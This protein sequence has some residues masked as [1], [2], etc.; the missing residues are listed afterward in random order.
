LAKLKTLYRGEFAKNSCQK[1]LLAFRMPPA[2]AG[3][4]GRPHH[5]D[6]SSR[7]ATHQPR[8]ATGGG[9]A[10]IIRKLQGGVELQMLILP[11]FLL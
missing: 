8:Q 5:G 2:Y 10:R 11:T 1:P 7:C 6:R 4:H 9:L 3:E